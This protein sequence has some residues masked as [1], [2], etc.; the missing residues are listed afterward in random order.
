MRIFTS[1]RKWRKDIICTSLLG[2]MLHISSRFSFPVM[3]LQ[4]NRALRHGRAIHL[5]AGL[6]MIRRISDFLSIPRLIRNI[7]LML[8]GKRMTIPLTQLSSGSS[9]SMTIKICSRTKRRMTMTLP[10]FD[11]RRAELR[12]LRLMRI[13]Q[14]HGM[15]S[16][17]AMRMSQLLSTVTVPQS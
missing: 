4:A 14:K 9:Q 13:S 15:D 5:K 12:F 11:L 2:R 10:L 7:I 17:S 6:F 1:I 16:I 8:G 3:K